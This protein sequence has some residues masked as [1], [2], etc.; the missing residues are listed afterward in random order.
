[1]INF[2]INDVLRF[3]QE[4]NSS[5]LLLFIAAML[6]F[7]M[8]VF[9]ILIPLL[10]KKYQVYKKEIFIFMVIMNI[11]LLFMG[12]LLT[13]IML[14]FGLAWATNRVSRPRYEVLNIEEYVV[15]EFPMITSHFS[16]GVL[17]IESHHNRTIATDEKIKALRILYESNVQNNIG[18]I[19][20]F[21]SDSSDETRLYAFSLI[22]SF[23]KKLNDEVKNFHKKIESAKNKHDLEMFHL[24]LAQSYW[25]FIFHGV[26]NEQL[27]RFYT[28]KIE[29]TLSHV[30]HSA[31]ASMLLGKIHLFNKEYEKA[32]DAFLKS[33]EQGTPKKYIDTYLAEICYGQKAYNQI[34]QFME[35]EFVIDLRLKPLYQTWRSA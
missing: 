26:A 31:K 27:A 17:A 9:S 8:F 20:L 28:T 13:L 34:A 30:E 2:N 6:L 3:L 1:M 32:E 33:V 5:K 12:I 23:E 11:G 22:S 16:E 15:D 4:T 21:L 29:Q 25:Q 7:W 14:L 35:K 18:K 10:P 24:R 19:K